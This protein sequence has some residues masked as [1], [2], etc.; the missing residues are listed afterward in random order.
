MSEGPVHRKDPT[1]PVKPELPNPQ[2]GPLKPAA[3]Q[4]PAKV[5]KVPKHFAR[6][7]QVNLSMMVPTTKLINHVSWL[8]E[9]L[10]S[11]VR[12]PLVLPS[13]LLSRPSAIFPLLMFLITMTI[14][15][16]LAQHA[17]QT[18]LPEPAKKYFGIQDAASFALLIVSIPLAFI[19][20]D[21]LFTLALE[22]THN[23]RGAGSWSYRTYLASRKYAR[24]Q[25][26][27][28]ML[29]LVE[30]TSLLLR[31]ASIAVVE[32]VDAR[33]GSPALTDAIRFVGADVVAGFTNTVVLT[34]LAH[35]SRLE[36]MNVNTRGQK[37]AFIDC[38]LPYFVGFALPMT[39]LHWWL[40]RRLPVVAVP[41]LL[42]AIIGTMTVATSH[43]RPSDM[44][45]PHISSVILTVPHKVLCFI[46]PAVSGRG[47]S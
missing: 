8:A 12:N 43:V 25:T 27:C 3:K 32:F 31:A 34:F 21:R 36:R 24:V 19:W 47:M 5:A 45:R 41:F 35:H 46:F 11:G 9:G 26:D 30:A 10:S 16:A 40:S 15:I 13:L 33:D 20:Q 18:Y 38:R 7:Q 17:A 42:P 29:L 44:G 6:H 28:L 37:A 14:P 22:V 23:I 39:M 1:S 2:N 4:A